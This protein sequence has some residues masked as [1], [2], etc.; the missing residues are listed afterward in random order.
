ML[1]LRIMTKDELNIRNKRNMN[2]R[3][4]RVPRGRHGFLFFFYPQYE[5]V[6]DKR[7]SVME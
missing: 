3:L 2:P 5:T 6:S 7:D 1:S 4:Q